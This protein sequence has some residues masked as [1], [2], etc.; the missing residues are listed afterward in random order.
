MTI[1]GT[2][3]GSRRKAARGQ[4]SPVVRL[5]DASVRIGGRTVWREVGLELPA[6]EIMA[7]LGPNGA[8]KSTLLKTIV[9]LLPLATGSIDV[10]GQTPKQARSRIGYVPQRRHFGTDVRLRGWDLVRLGLDGD[11]WGFAFTQVWRR[12]RTGSPGRQVDEALD[13][14]GARGLARRPIGELSGGEQQRILIAQALVRRPQLLLLDEPLESLD[15]AFQSE[16]SRLIQ[17]VSREV[18]ASVLL[19]AHDVNPL[20][21]YVDRICYIAGGRAAVGT[22]DQVITSRTLSALYGMDVEVIHARNGQIL[23]AGRPEGVGCA[24]HHEDEGTSKQ[25]V[26]AG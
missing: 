11:R 13:L 9:G 12:A 21:P 7:V 26:V 6:G 10:L 25:P 23:V 18:H 14:V 1:A 24:D 2:V 15:L 3:T 16:I 8:G 17:M 4:T 20:L 19:V 22:P 5:T